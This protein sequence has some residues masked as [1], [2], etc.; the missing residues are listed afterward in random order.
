MHVVL[1]GCVSDKSVETMLAYRKAGTN[2]RAVDFPCHMIE[3]H[4]KEN[5]E[6]LKPCGAPPEE[7]RQTTATCWSSA[8]KQLEGVY[9]MV[10]IFSLKARNF[11][12]IFAAKKITEFFPIP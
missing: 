11:K 2:V 9:I 8:G 12:F 3:V 7:N 5:C 6:I 10:R 4:G 1:N